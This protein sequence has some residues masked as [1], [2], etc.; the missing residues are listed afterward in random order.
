MRY[1]QSYIQ[2]FAQFTT[3]DYNSGREFYFFSHK[4]L[5]L[6]TNLVQSR[7]KISD[8]KV[9]L[10]RGDI[11]EGLYPGEFNLQIVSPVGNRVLA[12]KLVL[13]TN[14]KESIEKIAINPVAGFKFEITHS[15]DISP[16]WQ[17]KTNVIKELQT[18]Y[19]Q[20]L[21]DILLYFSDKT[22]MS[23]FEYSPSD[24]HLTVTALNKQII[25]YA[26]LID[27]LYPRVIAIGHGMGQIHASLE[28]IGQCQRKRVQLLG[29]N[30]ISIPVDFTNSP[31]H[32]QNDANFNKFKNV[33]NRNYSYKK[34]QNLGLMTSNLQLDP[35]DDYEDDASYVKTKRSEIED[36]SKRTEMEFFALLTVFSIAASIFF[37]GCFIFRYRPL[38]SLES[39][40]TTLPLTSR[41]LNGNFTQKVVATAGEWIWLG[42]NTLEG[43]S[44]EYPNDSNELV[45]LSEDGNP[46]LCNVAAPVKGKKV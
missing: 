30:S 20:C 28:I 34:L 24:Y 39:S 29:V 3:T 7:F 41:N 45:A 19:Q 27:Q 14:E 32:L 5:V 12:S 43:P 35:H 17:V 38:K 46:V 31:T 26:P 23:L 42:R 40:V 22:V 6:I 37:L 36:R 21:L 33:A 16:V 15:S 9:A 11:I 1:Q 2:V 4:A 10:V 13:V 8:P 18:Q 44:H 25:T